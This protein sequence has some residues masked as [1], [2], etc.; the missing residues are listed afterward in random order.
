MDI[1]VVP[2]CYII[3]G[4]NPEFANFDGN[5]IHKLYKKYQNILLTV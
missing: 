2:T 4:L 3:H 5:D 1:K